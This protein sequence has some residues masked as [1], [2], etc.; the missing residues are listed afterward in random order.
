[1]PK[2]KKVVP[3]QGEQ[4]NLLEWKPTTTYEV[5]DTIEIRQQGMF[6]GKRAKVKTINGNILTVRADNWVIDHTYHASTVALVKR[7][8][9]GDRSE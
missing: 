3:I 7:K 4:L 6:Y 1:M 5:G 9:K 8:E 2:R